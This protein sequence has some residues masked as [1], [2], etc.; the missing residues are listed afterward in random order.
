MTV[1]ENINASISHALR[2]RAGGNMRIVGPLATIALSA[3]VMSGAAVPA[4]AATTLPT[5]GGAAFSTYQPS[6]VLNQLFPLQGIYAVDSSDGLVDGAY[7]FKL[8]MIRTTGALYA[9][10]K[11]ADGRH[12]STVAN[13]SLAAIIGTTYGSNGPTDFAI[14]N[15]G[16]KTI[17][18]ATSPGG[19]AA[20]SGYNVGLQTG[21]ATTTLT[22]AQLQAHSHSLPGGGSTTATGSG[23]AIDVRE[24][25]L[26]LTYLIAAQGFF[27]GAGA[28]VSIGQVVSFAGSYVPKG[29][30][31][32][33]GATLNIAEYNTLYSIIGNTYGGDGLT[34]FKLPDLRGRTIVGAGAGPG[35]TP[36]ALGQAFGSDSQVLSPTQLP[37]HD[38][39]L[40]GGGATGT[41]GGGDP[42]S[43]VQPS[44]GLNYL[45]AL[46]GNFPDSEFDYD[47]ESL[48]LGEII[49]WSGN[50]LPNG[51][52]WADGSLLNIGQNS[53]L[54]SLFGTT[55][56]GNGSFNFAL[57]DLR[58]RTIIGA[59]PNYLVGSKI[60]TNAIF[61]TADNLPS[62]THD[63]SASVGVPES[64]SWAMLIAGFGLTGAAMRRRRVLA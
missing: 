34:T 52:A 31:P 12:L 47:G 58:G 64:A 10:G 61:L 11:Q 39:G 33:D 27:P 16:G 56:G 32:A 2:A 26:S 19:Q 45:V 55:Y 21:A 14:P 51:F 25:S 49:A 3:I 1:S 53:A 29:F 44:L 4:L 20:I 35:V 22:T 28:P 23:A 40:S 7:D 50:F 8:G 59:N 37:A 24:P 18:G 5:G 54:F 62:H 6:L 38:H 60:G 41:T 17:V 43:M 63:F 57:P 48:Y 9:T 42:V 36:I 30:R 46:N 13:P 15:L